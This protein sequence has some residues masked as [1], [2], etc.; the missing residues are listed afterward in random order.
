MRPSHV[1][2]L[3]LATALSLS[4]CQQI[5][6][7]E[8][9]SSSVNMSDGAVS[10]DLPPPSEKDCMEYCSIIGSACTPENKTAAYPP[11]DD[12]CTAVCSHFLSAPGVTQGN[13]FQCR[14]ASAKAAQAVA[15]VPNETVES[16]RNASPGGFGVCGSNCESYCQLY[17]SI[18][19]ENP[20]QLSQDC[21]TMCSAL[22]DGRTYNAGDDFGGQ[23]DTIQ[24]RLA[25]LSVAAK[26][27]SP[28]C[29][30][31]QILRVKLD[32]PCV[33]KTSCDY[34]CSFVMSACKGDVQQY[35]SQ[36]ECLNVCNSGVIPLGEI[37]DTEQ[38]SISC[39]IYHIYNSIRPNGASSHCAHTGAGG[40]GHC[41]KTCEVYCK[42]SQKACGAFPGGDAACQQR[43]ASAIG[44][45][46]PTMQASVGYSVPEGKMG[47]NTIDCLLY[48]TTRAFS[49]PAECTSA[50]GQAGGECGSP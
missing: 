18:C 12:F 28:H 50:F 41:G 36:Q 5:I 34:Y 47:G 11:M 1:C 8:E 48:H 43:C 9:R 19:P 23:S 38:D 49:N 37:T 21:V 33:Q 15:S 45:D 44:S 31:A 3:A 42:L 16:C 22:R 6:G 29:E 20:T 26:A 24:C 10:A 14:L 27:Q 39:R 30:H 35:E 2:G 17:D 4:G 7:L 40:D 46:D 13:S 32:N 25:H